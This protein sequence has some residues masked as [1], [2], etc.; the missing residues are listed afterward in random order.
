MSYG[1]KNIKVRAIKDHVIVKNMDFGE[2]VSTGGIVI[3]SDDAKLHGVKPR[4]AEIYKIGPEQQDYK[5]GQ[6]I[7]IE[8]GRW[9]RKFA[10][11]D[12]ESEIDIQR[13]DI[14]AIL[15]TADNRPNDFFIGTEVNNGDSVTFRPEDFVNR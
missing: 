5:V 2:M 13:V 3:Q 6:W 9:T 8:H 4:W 7:L 15:A 1:V 12:G 11:D 10:I 14:S